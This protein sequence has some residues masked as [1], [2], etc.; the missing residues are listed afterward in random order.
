MHKEKYGGGENLNNYE[1]KWQFKN[2][3]NE[4]DSEYIK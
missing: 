3:F 2:Y 4:I 1:Y